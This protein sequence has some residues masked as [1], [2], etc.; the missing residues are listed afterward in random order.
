[1]VL[2]TLRGFARWLDVSRDINPT[3]TKVSKRQGFKA[4]ALAICQ[5]V[6][7]VMKWLPVY[8]LLRVHSQPQPE[9]VSGGTLRPTTRK[10]ECLEV[11]KR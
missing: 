11:G 4:I 9:A 8:I 5:V 2:V 1:M 3:A 7:S 10:L 6:L